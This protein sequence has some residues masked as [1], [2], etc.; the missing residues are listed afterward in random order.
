M[1][2]RGKLACVHVLAFRVPVLV[3]QL[4]TVR[5]KTDSRGGTCIRPSLPRSAAS[6]QSTCRLAPARLREVRAQVIM[7]N[8]SIPSALEPPEPLEPLEPPETPEQPEPPPEP[9]PTMIICTRTSVKH[10]PKYIQTDTHTHKKTESVTSHQKKKTISSS[11]THT[12][13]QTHTN[14]KTECVS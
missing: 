4:V 3:Q 7:R 11:N 5:Q 12:H 14:K 2:D 10:K 13:A 6:L 9:S 1:C 8:I